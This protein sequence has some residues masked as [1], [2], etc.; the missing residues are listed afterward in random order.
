M[1]GALSKRAL[2]AI[3]ST[4]GD[5]WVGVPLVRAPLVEVFW[6]EPLI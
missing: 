3:T 1:K 6:L 4:M 5:S 2:R